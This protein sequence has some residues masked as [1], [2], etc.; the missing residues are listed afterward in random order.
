MR[1]KNVQFYEQIFFIFA[2]PKEAQQKKWM[3]QHI[4]VYTVLDS[5][6]SDCWLVEILAAQCV[7]NKQIVLFPHIFYRMSF[8]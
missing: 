4:P 1:E 3:K 7:Y 5:K 2:K 8:L 6:S